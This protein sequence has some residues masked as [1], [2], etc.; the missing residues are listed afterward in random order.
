[1]KHFNKEQLET[2]AEYEPNFFRAVH[3]DYYRTMRSTVIDKLRDMYDSV[4]DKPYDTNWSCN[5]CILSFLK[6]I[7]KKYYEDLDIYKENSRKLIEAIDE[8]MAEVGDDDGNNIKEDKE[9]DR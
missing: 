1:M 5:H 8:V 4:A 7:G 3:Q 9:N 2:L 6:T